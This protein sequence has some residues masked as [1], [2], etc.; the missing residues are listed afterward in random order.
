MANP[1]Q[2]PKRTRFVLWLLSKCPGVDGVNLMPTH[3]HLERCLEQD[4][5][6]PQP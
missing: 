5:K 4:S 1:Y 6:K 2:L 3:Q